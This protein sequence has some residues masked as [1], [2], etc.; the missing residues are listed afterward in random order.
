MTRLIT[1]V[2]GE[3]SC[4]PCSTNT[5]SKISQYVFTYTLGAFQMTASM[6]CLGL[7]YL[8]SWNAKSEDLVS[9]CPQALLKL[10]PPSVKSH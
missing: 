8:A 10:K 4:N 7:N 9:Y 1:Y 5:C 6:L 2:L 3:I